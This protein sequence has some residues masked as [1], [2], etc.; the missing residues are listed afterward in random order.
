M[1][2]RGRT[3]FFQGTE[4]SEDDDVR[5]TISSFQDA[6]EEV[7]AFPEMN[8]EYNRAVEEV[9]AFPEMND[10]YN[11]AVEEVRSFPEIR[12]RNTLDFALRSRGRR[13]R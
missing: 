6:V 13:S 8:N 10:E 4:D 1:T 3:V 11:R 2:N 12:P 5:P 7:R 9:R